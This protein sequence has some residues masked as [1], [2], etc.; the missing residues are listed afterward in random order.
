[1]AEDLCPSCGTP[2][3]PG[4]TFCINCGAKRVEIKKD[5]TGAAAAKPPES[6]EAPRPESAEKSRKARK[7]K[8]AGETRP[9]E[10]EV[11]GRLEKEAGEEPAAAES[12]PPA[13]E[14]KPLE[15]APVA[16]A[17]APS[18]P[19]P[20]GEELGEPPPT[21]PKKKSKKGC[22]VALVVAG[23]VGL[24]VVVVGAILYFTGAFDDLAV[25][26]GGAAF[27]HDFETVTEKDF[28]V[29]QTGPETLVKPENGM[30][31]VKNA[32]V[33][34]NHDPGTNYT[35]TCVVFVQAV[36]SDSGWAGLSLRVNPK[37]GDRYSFEILPATRVARIRKI[38]GKG[39]PLVLATSRVPAL[40]VGA[41]F[42]VAAGVSGSDLTMEV[43]GTVVGRATDIGLI[44]GP[45]GFEVRGATAYF[46]DLSVETE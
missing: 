4:G 41:P 2:Y 32:L 24:I 17:P 25:S 5:E 11:L 35:A 26:G 27:T 20:L 31:K 39:E 9:S 21:E 18:P 33:G 3:E 15:A 7:G 28:A 19:P 23:I 8:A 1:M 10:E 45:M 44:K 13:P 42:T 30:L 37:G 34:V 38:A 14:V 43:N 12:K 36:E 6:K 29:W 40:Q 46:D 22:C 16:P